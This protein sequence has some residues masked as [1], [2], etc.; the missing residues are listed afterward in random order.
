MID[1]IDSNYTYNNY[2]KVTKSDAA[3]KGAFEDIRKNYEKNGV[4]YEREGKRTVTKRQEELPKQESVPKS[5][6][7]SESVFTFEQLKEAVRSA[8]AFLKETW[9]MIWEDTPKEQEAQEAL[10]ERKET[11]IQTKAQRMEEITPVKEAAPQESEVNKVLKSHDLKA[12]NA[13]LTNNGRIKPA[14][15]SNLL[16]TYDK[17]GRI[18]QI[19]SGTRER[20]LHGDRNF[21]KQ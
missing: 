4:I 6:E 3:D 2:G 5:R 16:T 17:R 21:M 11:E 7:K 9:R 18:V 19:E 12:L 1:K 13:L 15:N 10:S 20:I 14:R 8:I